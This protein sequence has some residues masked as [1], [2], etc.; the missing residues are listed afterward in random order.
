MRCLC[1]PA[2][3][4][5]LAAASCAP[6]APAPKG[7]YGPTAPLEEVVA[8]INRNNAAIPTLFARH[9]LEADIVDPTT[10]KRY[11]VN[12][13]GDIFV[14]KPAELYLR[15]SKDPVPV[16]ELGAT[17]DRFWLTAFIDS[18]RHWWGYNRN[19]G[20]P[21]MADLPIRPDLLG[22]VLG[23][24][25]ISTD[26]L[27]L[28]A[29]TLRFN[30][31]ADVYMLV[32]HDVTGQG[33]AQHW[34]AQKEIWYTRADLRPVKVLLFD[35]T[36]RILLRAN[37][38][39]HKRL[40]VPGTATGQGPWIATKFDLFFPQNLSTLKLELSDLALTSR[41]GHPKEGTIRFPE[42]PD[43]PPANRIQIDRN[44]D[45]GPVP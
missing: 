11:F 18:G 2:V 17:A 43:V 24:G 20:K 10:G 41:T 38:T 4:L 14:R 25:Q 36:G 29:P 9:Y 8:G 21:C 27:E 33:D 31:D 23:I 26:L 35:T 19:A 30:N 12:A 22:E 28:P 15:A 45:Q 44:C 32:W 3:L 6:R 13:S 5:L 1:L 39:D 16:F 40:E 42:N 7:Y 34:Y 37:L